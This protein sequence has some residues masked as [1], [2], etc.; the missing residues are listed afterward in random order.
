LTRF[1]GNKVFN[2]GNSAFVRLNKRTL[3]LEA[4]ALR[5]IKVG[6]EIL[7]TCES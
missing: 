7:L 2:V 5:E 3:G 6:E 1:C 4:V